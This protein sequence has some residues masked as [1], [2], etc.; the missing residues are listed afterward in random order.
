MRKLLILLSLTLLL[1]ACSDAVAKITNPNGAVAQIGDTTITRGQLF[2]F[3]SN[4]DTST[5][6]I[7]MAKNI[8]REA[9]VGVTQE[10]RDLAQED[11]DVMKGILKDDFLPGIKRLGFLSEEDYVERAL[12]PLAQQNVMMRTYIEENFNAIVAT[13]FPR[14]AR[15]IE[16][17]SEADAKRVLEAIKAGGNTEELGKG[18]TTSLDFF[19]QL[20]TY[21]RDSNIPTQ[22]KTFLREATGPTLTQ[23]VISVNNKFYIVEVIEAVP[24]RFKEDVITTLSAIQSLVDQMWLVEFRESGFAVYDINVFNAIQNSNQSQFLPSR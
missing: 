10:V 8:I 15:I 23:E 16:F 20:A 11:L 12:I 4:S 7:N 5:I 22:L 14:R 9:R 17:T 19:G 13:F 2:E 1:T 21:H 3:M 6:V 24:T 18:N